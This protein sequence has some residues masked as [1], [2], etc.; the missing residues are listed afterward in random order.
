MAHGQALRDVAALGPGKGCHLGVEDGTEHLEARADGEGEQAF[1]ELAGEF[2]H[3]NAHRVGQRDCPLV[4]TSLWVD[5]GLLR[6]RPSG[7]PG[8]AGCSL[9][10]LHRGGPLLGWMSWRRPT[11]Q[12]SGGGPPPQTSTLTGTTSQ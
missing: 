12:A 5:L 4:R 1:F 6:R 9:V 11:R 2:A 3:G 7:G 10:V 8:A